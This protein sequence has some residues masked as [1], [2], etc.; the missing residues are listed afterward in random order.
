MLRTIREI[1]VRSYL[2]DSRGMAAAESV[3]WLL[4]LA[5]V[6]FS[7]VDIGVYVFQRMQ[8]VNAAQMG[9]QAAWANCES[10]P[11]SGC[12]GFTTAVDNAIHSTSLASSVNRI[13]LVEG[14][15]CRDVDTMVIDAGSLSTSAPNCGSGG[16]AGYYVRVTVR[17]TY[18]PIVT[19]ISIATLLAGDVDEAAWTRLK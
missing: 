11:T 2:R 1:S 3:F 4:L 18:T 16:G 15:S 19:G 12:T 13:G 6:L 10:P 14:Y 9:A 17:F 7:I 5:P 8:V